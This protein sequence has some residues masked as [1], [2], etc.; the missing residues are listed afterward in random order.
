MR[1]VARSIVAA[2]LVAAPLLSAGVAVSGA[3]A[4]AAPATGVAHY[5]HVFLMIEE[6]HPFNT[7]I[8]NPNAPIINALA[9]DY[10]LATAYNSTSDP[11]EPNYV[12]MLG[13][14]DFGITSDDPYYFPGHTVDAPNLMSQLVAA[15][16]T[17][18]GYFQ[19][20]PYAGYRGYCFPTKCN[21]IPD[22]DTQYVAKH[23]GIVNFA[24]NQTPTE[25]A[26]MQPLGQLSTD[27]ASGQVPNFSYIVPD[28]CHDM[29][30]APPWCVDSG[31]FGGVGDNWL[32]STGDQLVG[33]V[34]NE[35]TS[36]PVWQ[37]GNDAFV[38]TFDE[39]NGAPPGTGKVATIVVTNHGPRGIK[40]PTSYDHYSLLA[41]LQHGFGLGCLL[42][43]CTANP[44]TPLFALTGSTSVPVLPS[45]VTQPNNG[46]NAV[47]PMGN[48]TGGPKIS[49]TTCSSGWA[50][51]K[52]P[53]FGPLDNNLA[54]VSAA[55]PTDAWAVG[56]FYNASNPGVLVNEAQHFDGTRW[57]EYP[58]PDVGLNENSL[59]GVSEL[60]NG[61]AY[62][63]GYDV[64]AAYQQQTLVERYNGKKWTVLASPSPGREQNLLYGVAALSDT[65]VWAVGGFEDA[66][67]EWHAL[68]EH[69]DGT[70]WAVVP[71]NDPGTGNLLYAVDAVSP[72]SVW[73]TG[74][75]AGP[76]FPGGALLEHWGGTSWSVSPT[77][78]DP[79]ATLTPLALAGTDADLTLAGQHETDTSPNTSLVVD[80]PPGGLAIAASDNRGTGENDL[81]GTTVAGDGSRWAVGW[82]IDP[83][84][85]T[86]QTLIEERT[87]PGA[88]TLG[89]SPD[90]GTSDNGF[91]AVTT[92][93]GGG[94]WAV[95]ISG[96]T[97]PRTLIAYHC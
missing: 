66:A 30:G 20:M 26:K 27:L 45:P 48:G 17:W 38:L 37:Q 1:F 89:P 63:V 32:V 94:M 60:S 29:H 97:N 9:A 74:Q 10:G 11:S 15:G 16:L 28:E 91:S 19:G 86:H 55:S 96:S 47:S 46:T 52:S 61:H 18:K 87:G 62:A 54:G 24:D 72:T 80:G 64:N 53:N 71:A 6:N 51:V 34:V 7:I 35:V 90:R 36:S 56:E 44:M 5:D 39:G 4:G 82:S 84:T 21:G 33:Q 67:S 73:A 25:L 2:S 75:A 76:G 69:Y 83:A 85:G 70:S 42:H 3:P 92:V 14:S 12:A 49:L 23:N 59:L 8:G 88:W 43:S 65:D 77:P 57:T 78:T 79:A 13:G 50:A 22:A 81:F 58:L 68:I 93:P 95:G 40:D 31:P 41:T